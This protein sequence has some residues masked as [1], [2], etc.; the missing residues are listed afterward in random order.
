MGSGRRSRAG[1][2]PSAQIEGLGGSPQMQM[3]QP[4]PNATIQQETSQ[5]P[6]QPQSRSNISP[7]YL[8]QYDFLETASSFAEEEEMTREKMQMIKARTMYEVHCWASN[9]AALVACQ[10]QLA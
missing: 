3:P 5:A 9:P 8:A 2:R 7:E 1:L 6:A 10:L 4:L